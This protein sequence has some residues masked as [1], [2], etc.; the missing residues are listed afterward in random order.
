MPR[1]AQSVPKYRKHKASGQAFVE[2]NGRRLYLG[3]HGTKVSRL[4]YDRLVSE[5]LQNGRTTI[6]AATESGD[7]LVV[8]LI[9]AYLKFA[10]GYYRKGGRPTSEY[11]AILSAMRELRLLYGRK[12]VSEFGPIALQTIMSRMVAKG[13][14]RGTVNK[15]AGRIKRMF[16]WGVSQEIIPASVYHALSTVSG[17]RKG[18]S[19][20]RETD[21]ILPVT[22]EMVES[23]L[24]HLP[25][26]VADVVRFQRLTGCRPDEACAI[27]PCEVDRS[28]DIWQYRPQSHKTEHHSRE[29]VVFIGPKAQTILLRY[30]DR[31]SQMYCFR[32]MDSEAKRRAEVHAA[33]RTP[34]SCGNRP[35][36]NCLSKPQRSA[37]ERYGVA[38]YRRAIARACDVAFPHPEL[39][40]IPKRELTPEQLTELKK[41]QTAHRWSPNQLRHSAATEIRHRFGLEA[42]QILLGH[43]KADVTQVYAERDL[44]KG[45]E[46]ARCIG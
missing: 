16:K 17:L 37:G 10:Q 28:Q 33:R 27:R 26:V 14:A 11:A 8:E 35:G 39:C 7:F 18:R 23:T 3:P 1:L 41:W 43:S 19:A 6:T 20:A 36:T 15:Q 13:W 45:I 4:E 12:S 25:R 21:P 34:L 5:W 29:R 9:A 38:A 32:P 30:L 31:D 24:R 40:S 42:A 46:I 2:L 22:N 44:A